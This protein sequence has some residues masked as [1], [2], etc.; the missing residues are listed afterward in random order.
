MAKIITVHDYRKGFVHIEEFR[1]IVDIDKVV[2]NSIRA[3]KDGTV[4]LKFYDKKKK[5]VKP[6]ESK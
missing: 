1:D 2:F 4:L 5:V 3:K 6:Y